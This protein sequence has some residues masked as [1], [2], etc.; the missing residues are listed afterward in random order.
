MYGTIARMHL[1]PG[2]EQR[3]MA[4]SQAEMQVIPGITATYVYRMDS[5]S[6]EYY[7]VVMFTSREAYVANANSPEQ[8]ARYLE[9]M[10]LMDAEPQW[11]DGEIVWMSQ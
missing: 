6:N 7:V 1:K 4:L 5:D 2:M 3:L 9:F 8:H 10:E 11:H